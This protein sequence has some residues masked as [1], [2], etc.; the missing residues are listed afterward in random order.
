MWKEK[1]EK[2]FHIE[3]VMNFA[4][5]LIQFAKLIKHM[6]KNKFYKCKHSFFGDKRHA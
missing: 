5:E 4:Q 6:C 3:R 2:F 1:K